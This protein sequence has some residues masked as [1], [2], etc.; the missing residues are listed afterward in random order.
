VPRAAAPAL[1]TQLP[2]DRLHAHFTGDPDASPG[3]ISPGQAA[4]LGEA[5]R[6]HEKN[7]TPEEEGGRARK[8][9][10]RTGRQ[11]HAT[12]ESPVSR[13]ML[14]EVPLTGLS[15]ARRDTHSFKMVFEER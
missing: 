3:P 1:V 4:G 6:R 7:A 15:F 13:A 10:V 11:E 14:A 8:G 9:L 12:H 5:P 2:G